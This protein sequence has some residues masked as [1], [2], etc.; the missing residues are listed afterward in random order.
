MQN[1]SLRL[2]G[3]C[4]LQVR[5]WA[6]ATLRCQRAHT[7]RD[8]DPKQTSLKITVL[9]IASGTPLL[10][11][12]KIDTHFPNPVL[13]RCARIRSPLWPGQNSLDGRAFADLVTLFFERVSSSVCSGTSEWH[14]GKG[15][16]Q[17]E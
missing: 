6:V 4:P 3:Q 11:E 5:A 12:S 8:C 1:L 13:L 16:Q 14:W 2:R 10:N 9:C 17:D 7:L 15:G